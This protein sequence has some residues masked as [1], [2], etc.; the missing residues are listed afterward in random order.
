MTFKDSCRLDSMY[1]LPIK[2]FVFRL[3][4]L[5][6]RSLWQFF[7]KNKGAE[8]LRKGMREER[9][10]MHLRLLAFNYRYEIPNHFVT[11]NAVQIVF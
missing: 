9:E 2:L 8:R 7:E 5:Q 6:N 4:C 1:F 11:Y 3:S 10:R